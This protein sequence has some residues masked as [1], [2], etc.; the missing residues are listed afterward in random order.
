MNKKLVKIILEE[1]ESGKKMRWEITDRLRNYP[2]QEKV[3]AIRYC[4][5]RGLVFLAPEKVNGPG[6]NPVYVSITK[7]GLHELKAL[8]EQILDVSIWGV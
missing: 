8:K 7:K 1:L 6:R 3:D 4:N 2:R 5:E